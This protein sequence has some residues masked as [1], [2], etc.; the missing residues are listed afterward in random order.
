MKA[1]TGVLIGILLM[2]IG[3]WAVF[4]L[5]S[6]NQC[7]RNDTYLDALERKH[8]EPRSIDDIIRQQEIEN[9]HDRCRRLGFSE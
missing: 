4:S 5:T 7:K 1:I 9:E 6:S 3:L 2:C 8:F